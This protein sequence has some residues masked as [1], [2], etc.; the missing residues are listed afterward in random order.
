MSGQYKAKY[1]VD[2]TKQGLDLRFT[3]DSV[4]FVKAVLQ[5]LIHE[6]MTQETIQ[7]FKFFKS[8]KIKDSTAFQLPESMC[9]DYPGSGGAGSKAA[10]RVQFEYDYL[11]GNI[12]DLSL[13]AFNNQDSV[14]ATDTLSDVKSGDLVVRDL[15]YISLEN[16]SEIEKNGAFYVNRPNFN[17]IVYELK[18]DEYIEL[19]FLKIRRQMLKNNQQQIEKEVYLGKERQV[20][21][22]LI[23][24][25]MPDSEVE[26]RIAKARKEAIKKGRQLSDLY[27]TRAS[28]NLFITNIPCKILSIENIREIYRL[29]WQVELVFKVWKSV[30]EIDEV[31]K[32]KQARFE[33]FLYAKLI[34][35]TMN[36]SIL[37]EIGKQLWTKDRIL[38]SIYKGFKTIKD[39]IIMQWSAF[40]QGEE[41]VTNFIES[42]YKMSP[43]NHRVEQKKNKISTK[44]ILEQLLKSV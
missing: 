6:T 24:E 36:W 9:E 5:T 20:K 44:D 1:N 11:T 31:K 13:H 30:V 32:M 4:K 34:W 41:A 25:M 2:I 14:N 29:R 19:D 23:I 40:Q 10:I 35:I 42:I 8:L 22:R 15:G 27:K 28:L 33:T 39:R 12:C 17:T 37:Q 7:P 43:K 16:L 21:S 18:N 3:E 38:V 26:K